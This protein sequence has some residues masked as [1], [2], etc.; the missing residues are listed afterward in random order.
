MIR[1]IKIGI[2]RCRSLHT[3]MMAGPYNVHATTILLAH[4]KNMGLKGL[5]IN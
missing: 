1:T 5:L 2:L 4:K 3:I